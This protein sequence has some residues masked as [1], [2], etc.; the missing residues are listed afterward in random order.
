MRL[1]EKPA[2]ELKHLAA[3]IQSTRLPVSAWF[4]LA[5][6]R[7]TFRLARQILGDSTTDTLIGVGEDT[8]F[9][10]LNRNRPQDTDIQ[11]V[12]YGLNPQC[13][14]SDIAVTA[15]GL[16]LSAAAIRLTT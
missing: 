14:A 7:E 10:E 5:A 11:V 15:C 13:H 3:T 9:T 1:G 2:E 4:I 16:P 6:D 12:S 8:H